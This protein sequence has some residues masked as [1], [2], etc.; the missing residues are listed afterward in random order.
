MKK[1]SLILI[2]ICLFIFSNTVVFSENTTDVMQTEPQTETVSEQSKSENQ[3]A[4]E[5][6]PEK[7]YENLMK[8]KDSKAY[9]K[10]FNIVVSLL[11]L[12]LLIALVFGIYKFKKKFTER[13]V[14]IDKPSKETLV[15]PTD[16]K[17]TINL[18][19]EKTDE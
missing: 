8:I 14:I 12:A 5:T 7:N 9:S 11:I 1:F 15:T 17:T 4:L 18:F 19:L 16:F 10:V 3:A 2:A 13:S 6:I